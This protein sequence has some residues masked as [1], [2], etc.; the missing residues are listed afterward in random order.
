MWRI[1][2]QNGRAARGNA[3]LEHEISKSQCNNRQTAG[4]AS[5]AVLRVIMEQQ[6]VRAMIQVTTPCTG[7]GL[8]W[9]IKSTWNGNLRCLNRLCSVILWLAEETH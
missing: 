3:T 8:P 9:P 2:E 6:K 4:G 7:D 5:L 1:S